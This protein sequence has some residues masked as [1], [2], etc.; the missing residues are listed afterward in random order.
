[1][2]IDESRLYY[3]FLNAIASRQNSMRTE[4]M[5]A[6]QAALRAAVVCLSQN[7]SFLSVRVGIRVR[8][9]V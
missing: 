5:G 6:W 1:M 4:A 3:T 9:I 8:R 7:F 2:V